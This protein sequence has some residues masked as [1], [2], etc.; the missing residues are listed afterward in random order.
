MLALGASAAQAA[1]IGMFGGATYVF[2]GKTISKIIRA[3]PC[4]PRL[5]VTKIVA[6]LQPA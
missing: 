2:D 3:S 1:G 5:H 6:L 4:R